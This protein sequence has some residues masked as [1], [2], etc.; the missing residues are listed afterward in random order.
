M[1][2]AV[3]SMGPTRGELLRWELFCI[4]AEMAGVAIGLFF[5]LGLNNWD[6]GGF[7]RFTVLCLSGAARYWHYIGAASRADPA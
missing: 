3:R 6:A 4:P 7:I 2:N 1:S 5:G